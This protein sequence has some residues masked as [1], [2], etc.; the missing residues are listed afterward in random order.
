MAM[1]PLE[2][3]KNLFLKFRYYS[4]AVIAAREEP[5]VAILG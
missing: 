2:R 1:K 4:D 5:Q 3:L